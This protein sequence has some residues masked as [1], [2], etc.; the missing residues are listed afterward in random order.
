[1]FINKNQ[2]PFASKHT[3][4]GTVRVCELLT[5]VDSGLYSG[6]SLQQTMA[7]IK[8]SVDK[9]DTLNEDWSINIPAKAMQV[10]SL[11]NNLQDPKQRPLSTRKLANTPQRHRHGM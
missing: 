7:R 2:S 5:E 8:N 6:Q 9:Q 3:N 11:K 4:P 1:M 10:L